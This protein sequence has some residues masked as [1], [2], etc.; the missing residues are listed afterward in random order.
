MQLIKKVSPENQ[1]RK[2]TILKVVHANEKCFVIRRKTE[3]LNQ[4]I[5]EHES[6]NR[7]LEKNKKRLNVLK[8]EEENRIEK[9]EKENEALHQEIL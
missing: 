6:Y 5:K 2:P 7:V 3:L 4:E 8:E 1:D 9:F